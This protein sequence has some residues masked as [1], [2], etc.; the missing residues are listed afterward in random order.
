M[1]DGFD[2]LKS[3]GAQKIHEQTHIARHHMQA[4]LHETFDDMNKI[5]FLGFISIL[6]REYSVDLSELKANAEEF[7][8]EETTKVQQETKVF[9][10]PKKKKNLTLIYIAVVVLIFVIAVSF[11]LDESSNAS[12]K[13][14]EHSIDNSAIE[15][16][17]DNMSQ[18]ASMPVVETEPVEIVKSFKFIS[19][20]EL[21]LGYIDLETYKKDQKLFK[22]EFALD[23]KKDWLL[24]LGHGYIK[25][26][27]DGV[28]TEFKE[29]LNM[30]LLYKDSKLS[31]INL[32]E[33]KELN[34]G[35]R[36]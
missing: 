28:V 21:W 29:K 36:W 15:N 33:F 23:P 7:Y 31:R 11:T 30:R 14:K 18:N 20:S 12:I 27:I 34:R 19:K 16:A 26:E 13:V 2:K 35:D 6:E 5:Q 32:R 4:L 3:I 8:A 1:S 17:K 10:E 24:S 9:V 25:V 22:G